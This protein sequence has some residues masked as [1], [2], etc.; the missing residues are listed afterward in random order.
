MPI[1]TLRVDDDLKKKMDELREVNWS[2]V[3]REAIREKITEAELWEPIDIFLLKEASADTDA[4]RRTIKGWESTAE[5]RKWRE[6]D[7]QR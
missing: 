3:A 4:L 7:Q 5:I 2:E 6:R 1:I